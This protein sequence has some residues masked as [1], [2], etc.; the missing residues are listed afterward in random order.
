[1][2]G[3]SLL[4][5]GSNLA[6]ALGVP[7]PTTSWILMADSQKHNQAGKSGKLGLDLKQAQ[8]HYDLRL[9]PQP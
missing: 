5:M 3:T 6:W 1:M 9:K 4:G 7:A 8:F 2:D